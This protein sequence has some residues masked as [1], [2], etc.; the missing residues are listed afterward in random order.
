MPNTSSLVFD[1]SYIEYVTL[2]VP[3]AL[4]ED[5]GKTE[6]WKN[7]KNIVSL[8]G[9]SIPDPEK[10][11]TPTISYSNGKI[12]FDCETEGVEYMS[13]IKDADVKS[14]SSKEIQLGVTYDISVYA[15]KTG[16]A[17]SD[18]ATA[19][20]CWVDVEPKMEG[21]EN[22]V[23]EVRAIPV[24]VQANNGVITV[25]GVNSGTHISVFTLDG[26]LLA[27]ADSKDDIARAN[28]NIS[29]G[30]F[31]IVKIGERSLKVLMK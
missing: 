27:S 25:K 19:T 13:T 29:A 30:V 4:L 8:N 22:S 21:I 28:T 2:H 6:P 14:Y 23:H 26:I 10:C 5:Y 17:N 24:L 16:F 3:S 9:E 12:V 20:L 31:V 11:A 1:N 7:F 15:A 18:V